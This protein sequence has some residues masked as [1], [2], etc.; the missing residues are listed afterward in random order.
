[1]DIV[2]TSGRHLLALIPL[3]CPVSAKKTPGQHWEYVEIN[4]WQ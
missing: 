4:N 3:I 1:M 2:L